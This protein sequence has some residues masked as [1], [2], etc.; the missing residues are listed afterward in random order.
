MLSAACRDSIRAM[1]YMANLSKKEKYK[2]KFI[3]IYKIAKDLGLSF[4]FLSKNFQKLVKAGLLESHRGPQ[5][6]VRLLKSPSHIKLIDIVTIIDGIDFFN[7]CILGFEECSNE[8]PCSIHNLWAD[9]RNQI[10]IMFENTTLED[11]INNIEK[12]ENIK[13]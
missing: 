13:V 5:G 9:K 10:L 3:S 7:K 8:K 1:I 11:V 4:Y 6:G 12:F 2:E